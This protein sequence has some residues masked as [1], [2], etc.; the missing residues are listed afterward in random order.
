[1][2]RQGCKVKSGLLGGISSS[3]CGWSFNGNRSYR[4][5]D[6]AGGVGWDQF[7]GGLGLVRSF[8][9]KHEPAPHA[10]HHPGGHRLFIWNSGT[11]VLWSIAGSHWCGEEAVYL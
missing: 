5:G 9:P 10:S 11:A 2:Q 3:S 8:I 6:E 4:R 7:M 1:M